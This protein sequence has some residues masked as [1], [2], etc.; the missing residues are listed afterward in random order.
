MMITY[1]DTIQPL[2]KIQNSILETFE[3][4]SSLNE[5]SKLRIELNLLKSIGMVESIS[6]NKRAPKDV[7]LT[8]ERILGVKVNNLK[9]PDYMGKIELKSLREKSQKDSLFSK[10]PDKDISKYKKAKDIISKFGYWDEINKRIALYNNIIT[11][12][13]N[14][15]LYLVANNEK[16][17]LSQNYALN[18][19]FDEVCA[20]HYSTLKKSLETK[21]PTTLWADAIET[22]DVEGKINFIYK[23]FELTSKPLFSEFISL[24]ERDLINFDWK[25]HVK[26]GKERNHGPRFRIGTKYNGLLFKTLTKVSYIACLVILCSTYIDFYFQLSFSK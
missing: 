9:T 11:K 13:N 15:G 5:I 6:P 16:L 12:P 20:W 24:I 19:Q 8:L 26:N 1:R 18:N 17:I 21:H 14:Q 7:G 25:G 10:V 3:D 4:V 23:K 2:K 22:T